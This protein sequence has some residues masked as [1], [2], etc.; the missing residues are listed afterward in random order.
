[1]PRE[2]IDFGIDLGTTNSE[3]AVL[4][5]T[6]VE[7]VKNNEGQ[8]YTPSAVWID[9]NNKLFVGKVAK[10][11]QFDDPQ[12]AF[13]EF[14]L[15]MGKTKEYEF[16]RSGRRMRPEELSAE[17]L[18]SLRSDVLQRT[19][20]DVEAAVITHPADFDNPQLEATR[21]AAEL[22][23]LKESPLLPEPVAASLAYGIQGMSDKA[24]WL[25]YDFGGGTFDAA[26]LQLRDGQFNVINHGGN[27]FLGGKLI[28]WEI[29]DTLLVPRILEQY[30][31][32]E[33][34]RNNPSC[35][36]AFAK[37]KLQA[38]EAKIRVSRNSSAMIVIDHLCKDD[39]GEAVRVEFELKREDVEKISDSYIERTLNICEK[40]LAEKNLEH[41]QVE[42]LLLVGG[43]TL[44][45][46]VRERLAKTK[47]PLE[48]S[49]D[50][51]TVVARGAAIFARTQRRKRAP[52]A[53]PPIGDYA[54]DLK[55][56]PVVNQPE[57]MVGGKVIPSAGASLA[58][59]TLEFSNPDSRPPWKG[60]KVP[61]GANGSFV[62]PVWIEENKENTLRAQLFDARGNACP[63]KENTFRITYLLVVPPAPTVIHSIGVALAD[64][65]TDVFLERGAPIPARF[66]SRK[67]QTAKSVT[68][69]TGSH[70]LRIPVVEGQSPRADRN[71][72]IGVLEIPAGEIK[73]DLPAGS[74]IHLTLEMDTSHLLTTT[75][76]IP[77]LD[78]LFAK[79]FRPDIPDPSP[80]EVK[81]AAESAVGRLK[82]LKGHVKTLN[83]SKVPF[84]A[85]RAKA[86]L[87][88]IAAE[89]L[90]ANVETDRA[91]LATDPEAADRCTVR[92]K[93]LEL[94]L[95]ELESILELPRLRERTKERLKLA[96]E[97]L[98]SAGTDQ[99]KT[100]LAAIKKD[101]RLALDA[102]NKDRILNISTDLRQLFLKVCRRQVW[103]W[104][105][106]LND[107][108]KK[109]SEMKDPQ[110]AERL[111]SQGRQAAEKGDVQG[112]DQAVM[113]LIDLLP[114][115]TKVEF[116]DI[117]RR[118][119]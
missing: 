97:L 9:K 95:D 33:F 22:A 13:G 17:I 16:R 18:K 107:L 71:R 90:E 86:I 61:V 72:L 29:V 3:I 87:D 24:I 113:A 63:L 65:Q 79:V 91:A 82:E 83:E 103:F 41:S 92:L 115:D 62:T 27:K 26:V 55:Y 23:G 117:E 98:E 37:L 46:Y 118:I 111:F 60:G 67:H 49:V 57:A 34:K 1:M 11:R 88:R 81:R 36:A 85:A 30:K 54:L 104:T 51:L 19:G 14:K 101:L 64:N 12:N 10:E 28:D 25:V 74:E 78:Q 89:N 21:R 70:V 47:I 4:K 53:P 40:V 6:E 32:T 93:E 73:R 96:E 99:D 119:S 8:E 66:R 109:Q 35:A 106:Y 108:T 43:P 84:D 112:C 5:G 105:E 52:V 42:K 50:P 15:Q 100:K 59:L 31:V 45:P 68:R 20:E 114:E 58:G 110:K 76:Y 2:T 80:E 69:G 38:E 102:G 94:A 75:A 39:R 7:V 56:E 116:S 48:F 44:S 77:V